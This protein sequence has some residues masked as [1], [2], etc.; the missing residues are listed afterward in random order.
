VAVF[1]AHNVPWFHSFDVEV[2]EVDGDA[3]IVGA[4]EEI[5]ALRLTRIETGKVGRSEATVD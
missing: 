5:M 2:V 4:V 1:S 3:L